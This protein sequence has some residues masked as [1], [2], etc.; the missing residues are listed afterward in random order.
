MLAYVKGF[1]TSAKTFAG[2]FTR[3]YFNWPAQAA[4]AWFRLLKEE[5]GRSYC[6][7]EPCPDG[8]VAVYRG[9]VDIAFAGYKDGK[10]YYKTF[11]DFAETLLK[12][13]QERWNKRYA[14]VWLRN[15][16]DTVAGGSYRLIRGENGS[17][18]LTLK[19]KRLA[20]V[21]FGNGPWYQ[22]L[23][24]HSTAESLLNFALAQHKEGDNHAQKRTA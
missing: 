13:A 5:A 15:V 22:M 23:E 21:S 14:A 8:T 20:L 6:R 17:R 4:D 10:P 9:E 18:I 24:P 12:Q 16:R 7:L 3:S 11:N 2:E 19:G 1:A